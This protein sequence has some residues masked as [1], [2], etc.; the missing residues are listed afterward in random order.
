[1]HDLS[2]SITVSL[3]AQLVAWARQCLCGVARSFLPGLGELGKRY[4]TDVSASRTKV[5]GAKDQGKKEREACLKELRDEREMSGALRDS[6][7][8]KE[9]QICKLTEE[10]AEAEEAAKRLAGE[11]IQLSHL[12]PLIDTMQLYLKTETDKM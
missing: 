4:H 2:A 5:S 9:Q 3:S 12:P 10:Y 6:A 8:A 1:V 7:T 11:I